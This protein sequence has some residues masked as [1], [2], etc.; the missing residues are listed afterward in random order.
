VHLSGLNPLVPVNQKVGMIK[1]ILVNKQYFYTRTNDDNNVRFL[2]NDDDDGI[3][4]LY[5]PPFIIV[6]PQ[7]SEPSP[8]SSSSDSLAPVSSSLPEY[9]SVS[10]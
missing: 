2:F 1:C 3:Y 10:E 4:R 8:F 7:Q 5:Q 6:S 9:R